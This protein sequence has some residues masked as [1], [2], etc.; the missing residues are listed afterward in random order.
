MQCM[1]VGGGGEG[2]VLTPIPLLTDAAAAL[3]P[4]PILCPQP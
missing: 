1:C 4:P 3:R 2:I